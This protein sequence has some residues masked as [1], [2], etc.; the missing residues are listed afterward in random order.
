[1]CLYFYA[2]DSYELWNYANNTAASRFAVV[3]EV[4]F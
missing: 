2:A 4:D 1:M 3:I